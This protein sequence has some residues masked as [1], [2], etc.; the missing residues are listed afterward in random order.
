M[1]KN[2]TNENGDR[3]RLLTTKWKGQRGQIEQNVGQWESRDGGSVDCSL[4]TTDSTFDVNIFNY[5]I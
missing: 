5:G 4:L 1:L 2:K 3:R